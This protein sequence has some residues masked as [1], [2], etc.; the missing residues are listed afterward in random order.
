[1]ANRDDPMARAAELRRR[2]EEEARRMPDPAPGNLAAQ[3]PET[4]LRT[5]Q[6]LQVHRIELELQN[7]DLRRAGAT[8]PI[9]LTSGFGSEQAL[10]PFQG[11]AVA[12]F[13][14]KP[15]HIQELAETI[16]SA[17][18]DRHGPGRLAP[19][20]RG[21]RAAWRGD[22]E[23]GHPVLDAQ[24][25]SLLQGVN[26]IQ[27][28]AGRGAGAE[29]A[30]ALARLV[31][32]ALTHF[33]FEESQMAAT[34]FPGAREHQADHVQLIA[35]LQGLASRIGPDGAGLTPQML[36]FIQDWVVCHMQTENLQLAR[37]LRAGGH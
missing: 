31:D 28:A 35:Q 29:A 9:V 2:A 23:T 26:A 32:E 17:L 12:G 24:H 5:L 36:D 22:L 7:E 3:P 25:R 11:R 33:G 27:A 4:L 6:E 19:E 21:E 30:Q 18:E 10:R 14:P 16:R 34:A 13:L 1:M 8:V 37:H 15:Y 20:A